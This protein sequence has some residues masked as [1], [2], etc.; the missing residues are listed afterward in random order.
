[1]FVFL[2]ILLTPRTTLTHTLS[3]YTTLFGSTEVFCPDGPQR[4]TLHDQCR[5]AVFHG[6]K[7][8]SPSV[9]HTKVLDRR[10]TLRLADAPPASVRRRR[11]RAPEI[12]SA[13]V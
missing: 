10:I 8:P 7:A 13:H 9:M 5:H 12:G 3:P 11:V 6:G 4:L 2:I 1:M